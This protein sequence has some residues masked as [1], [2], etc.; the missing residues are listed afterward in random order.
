MVPAWMGDDREDENGLPMSPT[1][2]VGGVI[3]SVE[4]PVYGTESVASLNV[5][6]GPALSGGGWRPLRSQDRFALG[7]KNGTSLVEAVELCSGSGVRV[8]EGLGSA[9]ADMVGDVRGLLLAL[10]VMES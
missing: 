7:D 8:P 10:E 5:V 3:L 4:R 9:V 2:P 6:W 1:L